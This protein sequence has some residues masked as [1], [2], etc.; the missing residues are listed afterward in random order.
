MKNLSYIIISSVFMIIFS[1]NAQQN[2]STDAPVNVM[3][4][5]K[6]AHPLAKDVTWDKDGL[7]Y[8]ANYKEDEEDYSV[9]IND[10]GKILETEKEISPAE[11]PPGVIKYINDNYKG[12][13]LTGAA[14]IND[15]SGNVTYEAEIKKENITKDIMFDQNGNPL[16]QKKTE[17]NE[18]EK[19]EE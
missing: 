3:K 14:W 4:A 19:D 15:D 1:A 8:E 13:T 17:E 2:D 16:P 12:Y 18:D 10:L 9:I 7:N 6:T 11:L 5:F